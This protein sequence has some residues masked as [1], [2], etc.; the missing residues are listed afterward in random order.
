MD[1]SNQLESPEVTLSKTQKIREDILSKLSNKEDTESLNMQLRIADSMDRQALTRARI[2]SDEKKNGEDKLLY[3]MATELLKQIHPERTGVV[4]TP[5]ST[6]SY[7]PELDDSI[8]RPHL[9]PGELEVGVSTE[10]I[11]SFTERMK[12]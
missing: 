5:V 10:T 1:E 6:T 3:A 7:C 12:K 2:Q 9:V 11:E 4:E 8:P